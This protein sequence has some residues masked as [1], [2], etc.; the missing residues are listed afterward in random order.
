MNNHNY[1]VY[2]TTN[3]H[4]TV[5]YTGLTNNL[6]RR[7]FEHI[8]NRGNKNSFAGRY[9]CYVLVYFEFFTDIKSAIQREKQLKNMTRLKKI[10]LIEKDNPKWHTLILD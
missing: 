9:Y 5:L 4:R 1:Y 2:I 8:N 7:I 6:K 3:P 10:Q